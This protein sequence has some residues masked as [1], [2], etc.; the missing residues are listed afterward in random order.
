MTPMCAI[1]PRLRTM[2][3]TGK[4]NRD[5][6]LRQFGRLIHGDV[7]GARYGREHFDG[8]NFADRRIAEEHEA[9]MRGAAVLERRWVPPP[10][11]V[12]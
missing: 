5:S 12:R 11:E 9:T 8:R 1:I 7:R 6:R 3:I 4:R 2:P 10:D